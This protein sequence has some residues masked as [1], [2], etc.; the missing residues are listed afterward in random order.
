MTRPGQAVADPRRREDARRGLP[1]LVLVGVLAVVGV[2]LLVRGGGDDRPDFAVRDPTLPSYASRDGEGLMGDR[3]RMRP[4]VDDRHPGAGDPYVV[5]LVGPGSAVLG[6]AEL[7]L[8]RGAKPLRIRQVGSAYRVERDG[9]DR[10][11]YVRWH[12]WVAREPA[13]FGAGRSAPPLHWRSAAGAGV[14]VRPGETVR[15]RTRYDVPG[16]RD[17][18]CTTQVFDG[19]GEWEIHAAGGAPD[20]SGLDEA[21]WTTLPARSEDAHGVRV[22]TVRTGANGTVGFRIGRDGCRPSS[23][24]GLAG[25][26]DDD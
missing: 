12:G 14:L 3:R 15:L 17:R 9:D 16:S 10:S 23:V 20:D 26:R 25:D 18:F 21:G 4:V 24:T 2:V 6:Y 5:S 8:D 19:G 13:D 11:T 1:W 7:V 22:I